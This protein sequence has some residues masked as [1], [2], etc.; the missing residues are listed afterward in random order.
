[1]IEFSLD[2]YSEYLFP[3]VKKDTHRDFNDYK[4]SIVSMHHICLSYLLSL[5]LGMF[6]F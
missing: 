1:M 4:Y 5:L 2:I 6:L 3:S